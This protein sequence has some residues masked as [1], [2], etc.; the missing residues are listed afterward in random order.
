MACGR[1]GWV[2]CGVYEYLGVGRIFVS[3]LDVVW[4]R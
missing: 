4:V 2:S 3:E 1:I